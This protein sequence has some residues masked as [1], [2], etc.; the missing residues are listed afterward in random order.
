MCLYVLYLNVRYMHIQAN[1]NLQVACI[2]LYL[3]VSACMWNQILTCIHVHMI[4]YRSSILSVSA[5]ISAR[6]TVT[7]DLTWNSYLLGFCLYLTVSAC[8]C[9]YILLYTLVLTYQCLRPLLRRGRCGTLAALPL[10]VC[11]AG[12]V[13]AGRLPFLFGL[14]PQDRTAQ[15]QR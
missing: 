10:H 12:R 6:H 4:W 5:C 13:Y 9:L 11:H 8:I 1:M 15:S 3:I 7:Y 14:G 2:C